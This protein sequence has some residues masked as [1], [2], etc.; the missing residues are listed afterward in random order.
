MIRLLKPRSARLDEV[1][2]YAGLQRGDSAAFDQLYQSVLPMAVRALS[3]RGCPAGEAE[4][5]FQEALLALWQ[6]ARD[7]RYQQR[8]GVKVSTYLVQ[9]CRNRWIDKTRKVSFRKT[10]YADVVP[11]N[12]E[13]STAEETAQREQHFGA[14]DAGFAQLGERCQEMLRAFY[15]NKVALATLAEQRGIT[16]QTAKN[17][18]YRCMQKLKKLC[19][20][21]QVH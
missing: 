10:D 7:G 15:F 1:Q 12:A 3:D 2:L 18:K 16:P 21:A 9:L 19:T 20:A 17:E 6:N 4:D 13:E 11:E 8:E 14:L 5:I